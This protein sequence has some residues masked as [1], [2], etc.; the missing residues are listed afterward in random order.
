M[1]FR[2]RRKRAFTLIEAVLALAFTS[3]VTLMMIGWV[4]SA[5]STSS[6]LLQKN[7]PV[8]EVSYLMATIGSDITS[9]SVCDPN[10]VGTPINS[11]VWASAAS[12]LLGVNLYGVDSSGNPTL[13]MWLYVPAN[14]AVTGYVERAVVAQDANSTC[15]F[16]ATPSWVTVAQNVTS[17]SIVPTYQGASLLGQ[18]PSDGGCTGSVG[19]PDDPVNCYT[20]SL[21]IVGAES[22][23]TASGAA[24]SYSQSFDQTFAL[25]LTGSH[26]A[27]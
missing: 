1:Q 10:G 2:S 3:V 13:V 4:S 17:F 8:G 25:N 19:S 26:V 24:T 16:S 7:A 21:E 9:A 14:G 6:A 22:G 27:P 18:I 11:F 15:T 12:T 23:V 5:L 20:D